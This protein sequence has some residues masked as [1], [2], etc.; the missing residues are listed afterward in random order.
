MSVA[1]KGQRGES[2]VKDGISGAWGRKLVKKITCPS[3]WNAFAPEETLFVAK[4]PELIGDPVAGPNEYLRFPPTRFTA[5][6]EALDPHGVVT[7]ELACPRCHQ[8]IT[9]PLLEVPAFFISLVGSPASGKSYFLTTMVWQLRQ[10][11]P[12]AHISFVD[13][14]PDANSPLREYEHTL[15]LNPSPDQPTEIR[16]TQ[17]DDPRLHHTSLIAG[18][19]VRFPMPLQFLMWPT[20]SHPGYRFANKIGRVVVLYDNAGEDF[21]P[22]A[23]EGSSAA[24]EHLARSSIIM[25]LFD[26]TQDPRFRDVPHTDDPQLAYGLRP[27]GSA[28]VI[29]QET[30]LREAIVRVRRYRGLSQDERV[31]T[32]VV[33]VVP[34]FDI[35]TD[36]AG[37]SIDEEPYKADERGRLRMDITRVEA[38]SEQL[39]AFLQRMSPDFV[40]TAERFSDRVHYIPVS[41]FGRS[42]EL[43]QKDGTHFYGIRPCD[44]RPKWVTVPFV[45]CLAK[46]AKGLVAVT[47]ADGKGEA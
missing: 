18:A 28:V 16:K 15:F 24:V 33:V 46:W 44:V 3:C 2:M 47:Q 6:G 41:S 39:R 12:R 19:P 21:L 20:D 1:G 31:R 22:T 30:I 23:E 8:H 40:A 29:R 13:A 45:Y 35:W 17:H 7:H 34:K 25:V 42:P 9:E 43:I 14:E 5:A 26:P 27:G 36:A 32:P 37:V 38:A 10:M 4:H 11:M